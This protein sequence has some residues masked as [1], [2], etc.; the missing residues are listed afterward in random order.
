METQDRW[1]TVA[2]HI[3]ASTGLAVW[4]THQMQDIPAPSE[5]VVLSDWQADSLSQYASCVPDSVV[6][7]QVMVVSRRSPV[8]LRRAADMVR[9]CLIGWSPAPLVAS[10]IV[11]VGTG[12]VLH[13]TVG[14]DT[15][16][17]VTVVARTADRMG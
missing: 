3:T 14:D 17:S 4:D 9:A 16:W 1:D 13:D 2:A 8:W 10:P 7:M 11:G 6:E 12:P 5:Y 15:R